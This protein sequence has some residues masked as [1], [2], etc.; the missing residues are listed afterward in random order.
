M[1]VASQVKDG[2]H[3]AQNLLK[4]SQKKDYYK[5]LGIKR[6]ATSKEINAAYRK[7]AKQWHPDKHEGDNKKKAERMFYDIAAA[8][9]VLSDAGT[10]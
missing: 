5:I 10:V 9:E 4:Q 6:T 7:L 2:L 8:K 3:R 1:H